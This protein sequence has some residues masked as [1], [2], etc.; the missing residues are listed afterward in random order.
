MF[1]TP[2]LGGIV[3]Q[4][5]LKVSMWVTSAISHFVPKRG[6]LSM[7]AMKRLDVHSRADSTPFHADLSI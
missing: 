5:T 3:A 4:T 7:A 6:S 2:T 1:S